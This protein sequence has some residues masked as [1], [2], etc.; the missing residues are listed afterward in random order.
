[1]VGGEKS[2]GCDGEVG[3]AA[4]GARPSAYQETKVRITSGAEGVQGADFAVV[5]QQ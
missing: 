3:G 1:M 2:K 5:R 4:K